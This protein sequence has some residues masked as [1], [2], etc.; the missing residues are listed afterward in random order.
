MNTRAI[1]TALLGCH[2]IVSP[3]LFAQEG[4]GD[5][6][7]GRAEAEEQFAKETYK[8]LCRDLKKAIDADVQG[9]ESSY[10]QQAL[11]TFEQFED[12]LEAGD[13]QKL[14]NLSS[15]LQNLRSQ[16]MRRR[17]DF[18]IAR[19]HLESLRK[20]RQ[21]AFAKEAIEEVAGMSGK[22][23]ELLR[24]DVS[25]D[26]LDAIELRA[27][28]LSR[29]LEVLGYDESELSIQ[30]MTRSLKSKTGTLGNLRPVIAS[31]RSNQPQAAVQRLINFMSYQSGN[32]AEFT[33]MELR[34]FGVSLLGRENAVRHGLVAPANRGELKWL[35]DGK[36]DLYS[37][38][39]NSSSS[40]DNRIAV[41]LKLDNVFTLVEEGH[42]ASAASLLLIVS[43]NPY[44]TLSNLPV[45]SEAQRTVACGLL[46]ADAPEPRPKDN[47]A[48]YL[49]R[50]LAEATA[51]QDFA[52]MERVT[53]ARQ[54]LQIGD[55][56]QTQLE[57]LRA[58][59]LG[60]S[61]AGIKQNA[62]AARAYRSAL[63]K[64][65]TCGIETGVVLGKLL[66]LHQV[67][68]AIPVATPP[69]PAIAVPVTPEAAELRVHAIRHQILELGKQLEALSLEQKPASVP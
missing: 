56:H 65:D 13:W 23:R 36:D 58:M 7:E 43:Q 29:Q 11:D 21:I 14:R 63:E 31:A 35:R 66:A 68:P 51:R 57:F 25:T 44:G 55:N 1:F 50:V 15:N 18:G 67:D 27:R 16:D 8:R 6:Q 33:P 37:P 10:E 59:Q 5:E 61:L 39:E 64:G 19:K 69:A 24:A 46:G 48:T 60:E 41:F 28:T 62:E 42:P 49:A 22:I 3:V 32:E 4:P 45:I 54:K 40:R 12:A 30:A 34:E 9:N 52:T 20:E 26:D 2:F 53:R 47:A 17:K 38:V